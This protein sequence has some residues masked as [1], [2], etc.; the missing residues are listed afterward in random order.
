M[1]PIIFA[2]IAD[3]IYYNGITDYDR[4]R[5]GG[6]YVTETGYAH[7]CF[8]FCPIKNLDGEELC[9]GF[10]MLA[11]TDKKT[12][13]TLHIEKIIG[14][15]GMKNEE[16]VDKVHVV[17]CSKAE[18]DT[19]MR[20]VGFYKNA[21]VYR[22]HQYADFL[23]EDGT[24]DTQEYSFIAKKEDCVLL[25]YQERH[26]GNRWFV[27]SA[28][29]AKFDYGFGRSNIWYANG[30]QENEKLKDYLN[31]M[32]DSIETYNGENLIEKNVP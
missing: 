30:Y 14:C 21:T 28:Q 15:S 13:P 26:K 3:M 6:A 1:K 24:I 20:V 31:R 11:Q 2:R 25:P 16:V 19:S 9:L 17:F 23:Q 5:N 29:T 22:M 12:E 4:P 18:G 7:E 27:P 32:I 10:V 8:N